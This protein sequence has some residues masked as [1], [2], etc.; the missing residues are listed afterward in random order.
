MPEFYKFQE[1]GASFLAGHSGAMLLD[2]PGLG[3]TP[4][5]ILAADK[6]GMIKLLV[7]CP[8]SVRRNWQREVHRFQSI[9]RSIFIITNTKDKIPEADVLI[10][11][12][13]LII[14]DS[15]YN[16][17]MMRQFGCIILDEAH[18]LKNPKSQRTIKIYGK[19]CEGRGGLVDRAWHVWPLTGTPTP[20]NPL[21]IWPHLRAVCPDAIMH[22]GKPLNYYQFMAR[23]CITRPHPF[24]PGQRKVVAGNNL[25]EL[26]E[27]I[28]PY[29]LRRTPEQ[30]LP[31]LPP[32][33]HELVS[34]EADQLLRDVTLLENSPEM[35]DV[36]E[37]IIVGKEIPED[38]SMA[39]FRRLI[40]IAKAHAAAELVN[41]ELDAGLDK[42]VLFAWHRD[43]I[44]ILE[45]RLS[46]AGHKV[47]SYHGGTPDAQRDAN[48]QAFQ[49]DPSV[50]VFIGQIQ[51]AGE[52]LTLTAANNLMFVEMSW[53][54]KDNTQAF[55]RVHRITQE[56]SVLIRVACL[57]NS[58]D[59]LVSHVLKQKL[60]MIEKLDVGGE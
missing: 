47:V 22:E 11:N 46:G 26:R 33:R 19:D 27:R 10:V 51:A 7:I 56:R 12:Y 36:T 13:D 37:A 34:L 23:Y 55:K 1:E 25:D 39:K 49:T 21:E 60:A 5:S 31:D 42:I 15:I 45:D 35:A 14:R 16:Q 38:G 44:E 6:V 57:A 58:I 32:V 9:E 52:G 30:V 29:V 17:L 4:Q 50:R 53:T 48:V 28:K 8:A 2:A 59:E 24:S 18:I 41:E 3:K 54:P 40:G 20:N 43:V